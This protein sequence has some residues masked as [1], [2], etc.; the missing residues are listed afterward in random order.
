MKIEEICEYLNELGIL[1][2]KH[3]SIFLSLYSNFIANNKNK[4]KQ[5][6]YSE[7]N[8]FKII[9]FA[10]LKKVISNDKELYEVCS[11]IISSYNKNKI[12]RLYQ[13]ICFFNKLL[14]YQIKNRFNSFLF[15]LFKKKYPKRKYFPYN[16]SQA[17]KINSKSKDDKFQISNNTTTNRRLNNNIEDY[18]LSYLSMR[19]NSKNNNQNNLILNTGENSYS[20]PEIDISKYKMGHMF[21]NEIS[22][23]SKKNTPKKKK[24]IDITEKMKIKKNEIALNNMKKKIYDTQTRI[25]NYENILPT[26]FK[27][28]QKE[29]KSKEEENYYNNLKE[30]QLYHKLTE[31]KID[32][33]NILDRLYRKEI[34]K[35]FDDK[36]KEKQDKIR[37][38]S[39]INWDKVNIENSRK[40]YLNLNMNSHDM[41]SLREIFNRPK[42]NLSS[43]K[44]SSFSFKNSI[45]SKDNNE[46][47]YQTNEEE[48]FDENIDNNRYF[49]INQQNLD[50][51]MNYNYKEMSNNNINKGDKEKNKLKN[52]IEKKGINLGNNNNFE[53]LDNINF[54]NTNINIQNNNNQGE[55]NEN[56]KNMNKNSNKKNAKNI[57]QIKEEI[58]NLKEKIDSKKI[59][60]DNKVPIQQIYSNDS[61]GNLN[62]SPNDSKNIIN[63]NMNN[64]QNQNSN[65]EDNI[66]EHIEGESV[67]NEY[68]DFPQKY[69][70]NIKKNKNKLNYEMASQNPIIINDNSNDNNG[71][72]NDDK[73]N[74]NINY[75]NMNEDDLIK[76][77]YENENIDNNNNNNEP[78]NVNENKENKE[79]NN[80]INKN[81]NNENNE[82]D[83][84][85]ID[86]NKLYQNQQNNEENNEEL[87]YEIDLTN[88]PKNNINNNYNGNM[89]TN[90]NFQELYNNGEDYENN[91]YQENQTDNEEMI[92][93]EEDN[94]NEENYY[95]NPEN[96]ENIE[97]EE[98]IK[99]N[100]NENIGNNNINEEEQNNEEMENENVE[101]EQIE[102]W[103]N[104]NNPSY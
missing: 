16:P 21:N 81:K 54:K 5:N 14:F 49:N 71:N 72:K 73:N 52:E 37:P 76:Y 61:F 8:T 93:E 18:S 59:K 66:Q 95:E 33:R 6:H 25:N 45:D 56:I 22:K 84:E 9:L 41:N 104:K 35:K 94:M 68:Y 7:D 64:K 82:E 23:V 29:I 28:R 99:E 102:K 85:E 53:N 3:T 10:F 38:K 67:K 90:E 87:E 24:F 100:D 86:Y 70:S 40:K 12:V 88:I 13:G 20:H 27:N 92:E 43:N 55:K 47:N 39:P 74:E 11:N 58:N 60:N 79:N 51:N 2:I 97:E 32:P 62:K 46:N 42:N 30:E 34:I 31:K 57:N 50:N 63:N 17:T 89:G 91:Y 83:E 4:F 98:Y 44:K 103:R 80:D 36:R 19:H 101:M 96:I 65:V 69:D 1:D 48:N 15:L 77:I 78:I 75:N 26:S